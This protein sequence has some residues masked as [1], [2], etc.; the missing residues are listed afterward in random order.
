MVSLSRCGVFGNDGGD[1]IGCIAGQGTINDNFSEDPLFCGEDNPDE[2]FTL[3]SDSP[4]ASEN[5]PAC[6]LVG[7]RRAGCETPVKTTSWGR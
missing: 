7:A 5:N 4:C 3:H 6:G 2:P 1:W